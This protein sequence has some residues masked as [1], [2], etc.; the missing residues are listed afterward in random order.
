[1]AKVAPPYRR[2]SFAKTQSGRRF[3][4]GSCAG[5]RAA[6]FH[7]YKLASRAHTSL[8]SPI[9][10]DVGPTLVAGAASVLAIREDTERGL[11]MGRRIGRN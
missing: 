2:G 10:S 4:Y 5:V 3:R 1:M 6:L 11:M 9:L 7:L 8:I